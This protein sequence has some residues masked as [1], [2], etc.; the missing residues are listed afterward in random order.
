MDNPV[1]KIFTV[2]DFKKAIERELP[3]P[4]DPPME[5][6]KR[7]PS[8][9]TAGCKGVHDMYRERTGNDPETTALLLPWIV[10]SESRDRDGDIVTLGG[11]ELDSW[12]SR[13]AI[14]FAHDHRAPIAKGIDVWS[15]GGT[16]Q[17]LAE[18]PQR[19]ENDFAYMMYR[20]ALGN[21]TPNAASVGF[22]PREF[23]PDTDEQANAEFFFPVKFMRQELFEWSQVSVGSN[24]DAGVNHEVMMAAKAAGIDVTPMADYT[25]KLLDI[26]INEMRHKI[27]VD[28]GTRELE[29]IYAASTAD[30]TMAVVKGLKAMDPGNVEE[31]SSTE[32]KNVSAVEL[33]AADAP[34]QEEKAVV[35]LES[36][37]QAS[38]AT[39]PPESGRR[40]DKEEGPKGAK[41]PHT[42]MTRHE[43]RMFI[44]EVAGDCVREFKR[45]YFGTI[46]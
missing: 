11:W 36:G 3:L 27:G 17:S 29:W 19:E 1:R 46:D 23:E 25:S 45:Q 34:S 35:A 33:D 32:E 42:V 41:T 21:F 40:D 30:R 15:E 43:L 10:S 20:M 13:P 26:G 5:L 37:R 2:R 31:P 14:L 44:G 39:S 7:V 8:P 38:A 22:M 9:I 6:R 4:T 28:I 16:L 12:K 24:R 18:Y